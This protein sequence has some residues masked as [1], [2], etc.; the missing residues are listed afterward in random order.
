MKIIAALSVPV[1]AVGLGA[2]VA[3]PAS[4]HTPNISASC[5]GV[6][7]GATAYD[8]GMANRWSVTIDGATRSG[9]FGSSVDQT[10]PVPQEG[11][12]TSWSAYVEAADGTYHFDEA[13]TVGPC[14]TPVD[15]CADL[16]GS[17]PAGTSC[18]PPP[19]VERADSDALEGC[20][21]S[22]AGTEYGAGALTYDNEYTDTYTFDST[23]N[24]WELVTDSSPTIAN[25]AFTPWTTAEQVANG[26]LDRP[27]KPGAERSHHESTQLD[28]D[29]N[30]RVTTI[31][32][33]TTPYV[34]DDDSN[35]WVLGKPVKHVKTVRDTAS[36]GSCS[37]VSA[38]HATAAGTGGHTVAAVTTSTTSSAGQVP[39]VIDAGVVP[40]VASPVVPASSSHDARLP[41]LVL[42]TAGLALLGGAYR[43][44][45]S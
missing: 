30:V 34:Y 44:R 20:D 6:H 38:T 22:L 13:G 14:G 28:C 37:A 4:A 42:L 12:T 10:F 33:T 29:D 15:A 7:L 11:A 36:P 43:L 27:S 24:T 23:T 8:G 18:T 25:V 3:S 2:L 19:N 17:Q 16:P 41:V 1:L 5:S 21:L 39:T 32:D 31:V 35:T 45:R 9:T 26:C 40:A